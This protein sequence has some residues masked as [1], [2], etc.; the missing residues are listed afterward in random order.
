LNLNNLKIWAVTDGSQGMMSQVMGLSKQISKDIIKIRT[1]LLFP[2]SKLQ[3][4]LLPTYK[5]IFKN[6]I[7]VNQKPDILISCGRKSVYFSL[8]CKKKFN[9]LF[10]IH[11]QNPKISS[12]HFNYVVSPNHDN[13]CG[14][15][16]LNSVGALHNFNKINQLSNPKLVSCIVGG[17]NQHYHFDSD[18]ANKL[19][20]KL[21]ELKKNDLNIELN[22][23]TSRRT[24]DSVKKI[25]INK[26]KNIASI[27]TGTGEN[28]YEEAIQSSSF[29]I[30]TSDS[31][32]MISEASISGKP[33]Y[34]YHLPFKRQSRRISNFHDEFSKLGIT[35]NLKNIKHLDNWEYNLLNESE[36]IARIIKKRI[37]E[38]NI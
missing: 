4:G 16:V 25:I 24:S 13:F 38:E 34:I 22:V 3:P 18:E 29:F 31:T 19:C 26:L 30:V 15:N 36:R 23:I 21:I 37:I 14:N 6:K 17:N 33:I 28:P 7:P 20:E 27:W 9:K 32:S 10:T 11:I 2:W 1:E 8:Y 12:K 35:R 5:W